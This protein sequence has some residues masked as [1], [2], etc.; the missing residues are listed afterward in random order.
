[1]CVWVFG[2][3][4]LAGG[5]TPPAA[6]SGASEQT[7]ASALGQDPAKIFDGLPWTFKTSITRGSGPYEKT[8]ETSAPAVSSVHYRFT[9]TKPEIQ[10]GAVLKADLLVTQF[11][12]PDA[13]KEAFRREFSGAHPDMG[14]SYEW[15]RVIAGSTW[16]FHLHASCLFSE[17]SFQQMAK[18]LGAYTKRSDGGPIQAFGC[19]CGGGCLAD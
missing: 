17:S 19:R 10:S 5:P 18:N 13:A 12:K 14:L 7:T 9:S 11:V 15:D 6:F 4:L 8:P 16:L 3:L 1:M 2:L